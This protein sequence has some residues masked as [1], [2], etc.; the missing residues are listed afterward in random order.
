MTTPTTD[1]VAYVFIDTTDIDSVRVYVGE[2]HS[3]YDYDAPDGIAFSG[4]LYQSDN[5]TSVAHGMTA[6][7][8]FCYWAYDSA[9]DPDLFDALWDC[10]PEHLGRCISY[11]K[12]DDADTFL[13]NLGI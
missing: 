8:G 10:I 9:D 5:G 13:D 1:Q 11:H 12:V 6:I 3:C 7:D 4:T 2:V